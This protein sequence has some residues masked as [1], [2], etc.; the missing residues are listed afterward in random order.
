MSDGEDASVE[1]NEEEVIEEEEVVEYDDEVEEEAGAGAEEEEEPEEEEEVEIEEVETSRAVSFDSC[2]NDSE[3]AFAA[4]V[5]RTY[6]SYGESLN[7]CEVVLEIGGKKKGVLRKKTVNVERVIMVGTHHIWILAR[8][9][10]KKKP[11]ILAEFH[12]LGIKSLTHNSE[13]QRLTFALRSQAPKETTLDFQYGPGST[14]FNSII[15]S[16]RQITYGFPDN[17][18][19][20]TSN[21]M[22]NPELPETSEYEKIVSNYTAQCSFTKAP[23]NQAFLHYIKNQLEDDSSELDL[24]AIP[25]ILKEGTERTS[26]IQVLPILL[27]LMYNKRFRCLNVSGSPYPET[28]RGLARYVLHNTTLTKL[29]ARNLAVSEESFAHFWDYFRSNSGSA[30]QLL[31]LSGTKFGEQSI[32]SCSRMLQTWSHPLTEL[33]LSDCGINGKMLHTFFSALNKNPV[34]SMSIQHLDLSG[35]RFDVVGTQALDSWFATLK[36]YCQVKKLVLRNT[37]I[38]FGALKYFHH[39]TDIEELDL[40]GNKMESSAIEVLSTLLQNS[41]TLKK[42]VMDNC[43]LSPDSLNTLFS[44]MQ[45]QK[46]PMS[47]SFANNGDLAKGFT[48][49]FTSCSGRVVELNLSGAR[50]KEQHF[51]DLLSQLMAFK[52]L[53]KLILNGAVEKIKSPHTLVNSLS[54]IVTNGL[55]EL[56]LSDSVGKATICS[57]LDKIA[58]DCQLQRIDFS[59]NLLGDDGA[60]AVCEWLRDSRH[61]QSI[62]LD[63]NR[64][65]LNGILDICTVLSLNVTLTEV[66]IENDYMHELTQ[67]TG[68]ARKR[69]IQ[70]MTRMTLSLHQ[71]DADEQP[72]WMTNS[73]TQL[74]LPAPTQQNDLPPAPSFFSEKGGDQA[75]ASQIDSCEIEAQKKDDEKPVPRRGVGR[76]AHRPIIASRVQSTS[77]LMAPSSPAGGAPPTLA[78]PPSLSTPQRG[79]KAPP[80]MLAVPGQQSGGEAPKPTT[81]AGPA[82]R[83]GA[84]VAKRATPARRPAVAGSTPKTGLPRAPAGAHGSRNFEPTTQ[85]QRDLEAAE[86]QAAAAAE[87]PDPDMPQLQ[88]VPMPRPP[89]AAPAKK[90]PELKKPAAPAAAPA[91]VKPATP[92]GKPDEEPDPQSPHTPSSAPARRMFIG[93]RPAHK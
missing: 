71:R 4:S 25:V 92:T 35:N 6:V 48:R 50:M 41:T 43:S 49:E 34:M 26:S 75:A 27:A 91:R 19:S 67:L 32:A 15:E 62:N 8:A 86:E 58:P 93:Q 9:S 59:D 51:A 30:L 85:L 60:A 57:L 72:F 17:H 63:N 66:C 1:S 77:N 69:L 21:E 7:L 47:L 37:N 90:P 28:L 46:G 81:G 84:T 89:G 61:V 33:V 18:I 68:F 78:V 40:S 44:Y 55:E 20:I 31:D 38:V 12:F 70:A 56:A 79:A 14:I 22:P 76:A 23:V 82:R 88:P 87:E 64:I 29:I 2:A 10:G 16:I 83:P 3:L 80:P 5:A 73:E 54:M 11:Q 42:I 36:V 39:V 65:T 74:T 13:K 53:R 24:T 52:G 45:H